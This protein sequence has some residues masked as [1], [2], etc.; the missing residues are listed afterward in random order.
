[1]FSLAFKTLFHQK[2]RFFIALI[3]ITISAV[4]TLVEVAIYLGSMSNAT[5][6]IRHTDAD[7]WITSKNIQT[8][9]FALPF[10]A[11]RINRMRAFPQIQRAGK[12]LLSWGYLKLANGGR[13]QVQIIGFDPD[14]GIGAPWTMLEGRPSDVKGGSY[15][16]VDESAAQRLGHL[17]IGSLWQLDF[18]S[19]AHSFRLV[20]LS[21]GVRSFTT[22][23]IV[24]IAYNQ[25]DTFFA[26]VGWI[27]QTAYIVGKLRNPD[28]LQPVVQALRA[29]MK[30]NDVFTRQ[31]FI[32]RTIR[33]WTV[34]T[35]MGMA[36]FLTAILA[37]VIG[38]AI[39][40]QTVYAST[41]EHLREYGTLKAIG[42][43]NQ[44]I[45]QVIFTQAGVSAVTGYLLAALIVVVLQG[46]IRGAGV[47]L[48]LSPTLFLGVFFVILGTCLASAYFS[49]GK[50]RTLDPVM[51]FKA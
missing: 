32:D 12:I 5:N 33:Y 9:D 51:V 45:Y 47:P 42:A 36:F 17:V 2:L 43:R 27:N 21:R 30:D 1:M 8:F 38:G 37:M 11:E 18:T 44:E 40:G 15:M 4:L 22:T 16:I 46:V 35:G 7:I 3:G 49:V 41:L 20:G 39:V 24:F 19:K 6:L 23:P 29:T 13:E 31:E 26:E 50:I 28:D 25:L 48:Y 34:Q 14:T 10:P